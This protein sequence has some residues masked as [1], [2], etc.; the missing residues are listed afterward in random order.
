MRLNQDI[1]ELRTFDP[2]IFILHQQ[3]AS[4]M[5][6]LMFSFHLIPLIWPQQ[7]REVTDGKARNMIENHSQKF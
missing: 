1:F 7:P 2:P 5:K 3:L 4:H 6:A